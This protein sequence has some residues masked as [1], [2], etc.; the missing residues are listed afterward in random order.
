MDKTEKELKKY[1]DREKKL[2]DA[3][4]KR[5]KVQLPE[6]KRKGIIKPSKDNV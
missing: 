5:G 6:P 1:W 4:Y 3:W 2:H